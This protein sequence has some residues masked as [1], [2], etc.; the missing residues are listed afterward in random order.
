M[1]CY[2]T[3]DD[4]K[5]KLNMTDTSRDGELL[6]LLDGAS[7]ACDD[8]TGRHFYLWE[9]ARYFD[10]RGWL[11][12]L[13]DDLLSVSEVVVD[14]ERDG[15]YDGEEWTEDEDFVLG[16]MNEW[17]KW[18][19]EITPWG[20]YGVRFGERIFKVTGVWGYGNGRSASPWTVTSVTA[21]VVTAAGTAVT[22]S[23]SG[24][25]KAGHTIRV[26]SEQM[27]VT[28]VSGT[29]ATVERGVNG[30]TAAAHSGKAVS[31]AEYPA[32]VGQACL[33]LAVA[34]FKSFGAAGNQTERI[35][36]HSWSVLTGPQIGE[37]RGRMLNRVKNYRL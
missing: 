36:E 30:T 32:D 28:A 19:L 33:W 12:V 3:L 11:H 6:A 16:P 31:L 17:P 13:L 23:A 29:T 8:E 18:R 27:F 21:T 1:N 26:E 9:G 7:R 22:L 4:L 5:S 37:L 14:T 20:S 25:V 10:G 2:A 34:G 35:G 15:T 24:T